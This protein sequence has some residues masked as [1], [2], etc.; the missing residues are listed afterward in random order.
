M[1][2]VGPTPYNLVVIFNMSAYIFFVKIENFRFTC[3]I[4]IYLWINIDK[5]LK[6]NFEK[7]LNCMIDCVKVQSHLFVFNSAFWALFG[8]RDLPMLTIN[9]AFGSTVLSF[10][11]WPHLGPLLNLFGPFRAIFW[12]F[13]ICLGLRLGSKTFWEPTNVDYQFLFWKCNSIFLFLIRPNLE[14][15]LYVLGHS[16]LFWGKVQ[17]QKLFET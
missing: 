4:W 17:V 3:Q 13:G 16:Q 1:A 8:V 9:L 15:F 6:V 7:D 11:L 2:T 12:S 10:L 14:P 5:P